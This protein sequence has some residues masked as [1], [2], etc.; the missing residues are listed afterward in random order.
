MVDIRIMAHPARAENV[1]VMLSQLGLSEGIVTWADPDD[2][3]GIMSTARKA[4]TAPVPDGCTHRIVLQDDG[5]ICNG[6]LEIAEQAAK[7]HPNEIVT[8]F[9]MGDFDQNIRYQEYM[10]SVGVALMLPVHL[11][12][13]FFDF[14]DN[15][16][17]RYVAKELLA[18]FSKADT[19]CMRLWAR[20]EHIQCVTTVPTLVQHIGDVSL[21]GIERRRVATDFCKNPPVTGW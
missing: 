11:I 7:R 16:L 5:D 4:W 10:L 17:H 15:D 2:P 20:N 21:I 3:G 14:Y 9:H 13:R 12:E 8:F 18:D 19:S 1:S 6:F